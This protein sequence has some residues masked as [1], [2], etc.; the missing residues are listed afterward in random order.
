[1]NRGYAF[2]FLIVLLIVLI[3]M[4]V[5][6]TSFQSARAAHLAQASAQPTE[7]PGQA[8]RV[9]TR[10]PTRA[11]TPLAVITPTAEM[12]AT[13][14]PVIAPTDA[15]SAPVEPIPPP[16]DTAAPEPTQPPLPVA[17]LEP[18][19]QYRVLA[20]RPD[21]NRGGCCY[22]FG[23][24]RDAAGNMLEGVRVQLANQWAAPVVAVTKGGTDL[25][26]YDFPI[27]TDKVTW[28]VSIVDA[29]GNRIS[30][31]AVVRFDVSVAGQYQVD[32]Q[33]TY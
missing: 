26:K 16:E 18:A 5:A 19:F 9:P 4:Y 32:W 30:S 23:T 20:S 28:Y 24:V 29:N 6:Y 8:T 7:R 21:P 25:G 31:E 14:P 2:G 12:T 33:R 11:T 13:L 1:M 3:G 17:T 22:I 15:V 27:G 10:T